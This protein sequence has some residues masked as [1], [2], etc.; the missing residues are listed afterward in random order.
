[1]SLLIKNGRIIT[2]TDDYTGDVYI[3]GEKIV[4]VG[5]NLDA[6]AARSNGGGEATANAGK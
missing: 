5:R 3:E 4:A 2:A 1:M 6:L